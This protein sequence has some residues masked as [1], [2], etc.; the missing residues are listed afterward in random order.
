MRAELR[1]EQVLEFFPKYS[2]KPRQNIRIRW[3]GHWPLFFWP[4]RIW[5][6]EARWQD[7]EVSFE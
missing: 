7:R 5:V 4:V 2:S 1:P 6:G 3:L